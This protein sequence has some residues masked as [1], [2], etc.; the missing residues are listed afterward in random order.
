MTDPDD[1]IDTREP[2]TWSAGA[3]L[4]ITMG[5]RVAVIAVCLSVFLLAM[6]AALT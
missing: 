6:W 5:L 3:W 1:D 4:A 2:D